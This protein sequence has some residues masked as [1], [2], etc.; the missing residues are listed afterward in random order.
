MAVD[1]NVEYVSEPLKLDVGIANV[2]NE[3]A[4]MRIH[5]L[6]DY[7]NKNAEF[8]EQCK[9]E[10]KENKINDIKC[11]KE[12]KENKKNEKEELQLKKEAKENI[13]NKNE[14]L[15]CVKEDKKNENDDLKCMKK[16]KEK[17]Y[18]NDKYNVKYEKELKKYKVDTKK[19]KNT[20]TDSKNF[21]NDKN[22]EDEIN[23]QNNILNK[24]D[25]NS[26]KKLEK[27]KDEKSKNAF[28]K[29]NCLC[30][31]NL[32]DGD[33]IQC[34]KCLSWLHTVCCGFFSNQDK[35]IPKED[36]VCE[37]CKNEGNIDLITKL[38]KY[39][40]MLS[41]IFNEG[42]TDE[43]SLSTRLGFSIP[44][45]KKILHKFFEEGFVVKNNNEFIVVKDSCNK[46][47]IK[48]Y[49]SLQIKGEKTSSPIKDIKCVRF[50]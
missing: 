31:V 26:F 36:Y 19:E 44:C 47:K 9:K 2:G 32:S 8:I 33:M 7:S 21:E 18:L 29:T 22:V 12:D 25:H 4:L 20:K 48:Q 50:E 5:T 14:D 35:R 39:R 23:K 49:F 40:R 38:A 6:F 45:T 1:E 46:M 34:D 42:F 3:E 41:V 24:S 15:R 17:D 10:D 27:K 16:D 43:N 13:K 30:N 28:E 37:L 11:I